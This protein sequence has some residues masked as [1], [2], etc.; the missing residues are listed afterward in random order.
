[1]KKTFILALNTVLLTSSLAAAAPQ[2]VWDVSL[3]QWTIKGSFDYYLHEEGTRRL[4]SLVNMPQNQKMGILNLKYTPNDKQYIKLQYGATSFNSKGRGADSDWQNSGSSTITDYGTM[5]ISG[6]QRKVAIDFGTV[7]SKSDKKET[8]V[9]WGWEKRDTTNQIHNVIYHVIGGINVGDLTQ[10]D[11][12]SYLDGS[13]NEFHL[14]VANE[15]KIN[16][17][18]SLTSELSAAYLQ[19]KAY[20]HWANHFPP[21]DWENTGNALGYNLNLE[22]MYTFN[23]NMTAELGYYYS[24]AKMK[25]GSERLSDNNGMSANFS[26]IDLRYKQ[27]GYYFGLTCNL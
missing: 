25:N 11:N 2:N 21:W 1:M 17:R 9:F 22:F 13:F 5:G 7:V 23:K 4:L 16:H 24:Y 27:R 6:K 26:G 19:A 8:S 3:Q 18:M 15:Y 20:G 14:G 10:A 12:G